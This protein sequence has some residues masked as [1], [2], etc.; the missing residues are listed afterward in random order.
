[1]ALVLEMPVKVAAALLGEHDT[2]IWRVLDHYVQCARAQENHSEVK[3][4]GIDETSARRGQDY[5]SL[6]FDLDFRRLLFGTEGKSY[7]TV[8]AFAEDLKAHKGD[9]AYV[10]DT[11]IDI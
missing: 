11:C 10:T 5:I 1:M 7:E 6:F 2:R 9:P 4:V 8:R 3:R